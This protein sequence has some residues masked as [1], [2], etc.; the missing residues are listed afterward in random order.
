MPTFRRSILSPLSGLKSV[1]QKS[2]SAPSFYNY[3][4]IIPQVFTFLFV[5]VCFLVPHSSF[6]FHGDG[7]KCYEW[8][9]TGN[10]K[11]FCQRAGPT[12]VRSTA[13]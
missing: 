6:H 5:R 2:I 11:G 7:G 1:G 3:I 4:V 13:T 12:I 8:R 10:L 9:I